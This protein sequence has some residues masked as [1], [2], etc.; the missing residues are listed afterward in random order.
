[1]V[2]E[3]ILAAAPTSLA[4]HPS[5]SSADSAIILFTSGST[6]KPKGVEIRHS[7]L[8]NLLLAAKQLL[9]F[10]PGDTWLALTTITF[11]ISENEL[12][13]PLMTGGCVEIGEEGLTADGIQLAARIAGCKPT[14][15]QATPSTFK[16]LLAASWQG[17]P[18]LCLVSAGEALSRDLA[19]QLL[20]KCQELW[21]L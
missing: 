9:D 7:S 20:P 14:H 4:A 18:A 19:E 12:L 5:A 6:G 21:N 11:D 1:M 17:D 2:L 10:Q 3:D 13:M 8:L 16:A 15:I